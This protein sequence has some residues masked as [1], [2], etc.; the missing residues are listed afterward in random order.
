MGTKLKR[1]KRTR[2]DKIL[3]AHGKMKKNLINELNTIT[4]EKFDNKGNNV[5]K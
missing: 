3:E 4:I 2:K 5:K 1:R